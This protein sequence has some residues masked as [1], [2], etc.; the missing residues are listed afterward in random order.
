MEVQDQ[1]GIFIGNIS[2]SGE[3]EKEGAKSRYQQVT[4][5]F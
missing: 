4:H 3:K 2:V 1:F 5:I